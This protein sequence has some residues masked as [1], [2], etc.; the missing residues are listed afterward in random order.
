MT[1]EDKV[2]AENA[3]A[4]LNVAIDYL[5]RARKSLSAFN[6]TGLSVLQGAMLDVE[7]IRDDLLK[8]D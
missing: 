3:T 7:E 2:Q 4:Q 8:G 1:N 5:R 6:Y